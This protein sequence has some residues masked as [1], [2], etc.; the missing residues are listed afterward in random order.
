MRSE[1]RFDRIDRLRAPKRSRFAFCCTSGDSLAE[2]VADNG[3]QG[4]MSRGRSLTL[5]RL[6]TVGVGASE[7]LKATKITS[8]EHE[9]SLHD[10]I[11]TGQ[12]EPE[13][14][15]FP[16]SIRLMSTGS[17]AD[18]FRMALKSLQYPLMSFELFF[19][20]VAITRSSRKSD[21]NLSRTRCVGGRRKVT[22]WPRRKIAFFLPLCRPLLWGFGVVR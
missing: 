10:V 12:V 1:R 18:T 8:R 11:Y 7:R 17:V 3:Q 21:A 9:P 22:T 16:R 6:F 15:N 2:S 14:V 20:V 5:S 13:A 4:V 19:C